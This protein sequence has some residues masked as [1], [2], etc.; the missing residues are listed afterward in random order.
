[1]FPR[2]LCSVAAEGACI[3]WKQKVFYSQSW[4]YAS[5]C[6]GNK[7]MEGLICLLLPFNSFCFELTLYF[8]VW[9]HHKATTPCIPLVEWSLKATPWQ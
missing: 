4:F 1:M 9:K 6:H 8:P 5:A 2:R 7:T 3:Y